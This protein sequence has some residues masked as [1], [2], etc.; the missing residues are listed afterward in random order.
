MAATP[1]PNRLW[2]ATAKAAA[3][4]AVGGFAAWT[5]GLPLAWMIGAMLATCAASVAGMDLAVP[6]PLRA[7]MVVVLGLMLGSR[8]TPEV[9]VYLDRWAISLAA[10]VPHIIVSTAVGIWLLRRWGHLDRP[11]AYFTATPGGLSEMILVGTAMGGDGRVIA[12][13]H[14][15]RVLL[16]VSFLPVAFTALATGT[17][18]RAAPVAVA[19]I[20][21]RDWAW[22]AACVIGWPIAARLKVP[23][24]QLVGPMVLSAV[25]HLLAFSAAAPPDLLVAVA[26][27]VVGASIG[28]RFAGTEPRD[29]ARTA[30]QAGVLTVVL[31]AVTLTTALILAATTGLDT[32]TLVLAFAPGGLAEMSLVA[33]SLDLDAAF[34]AIHHI[35]RIFLIVVLAPLAFR[36]LLRPDPTAPPNGPG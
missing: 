3:I 25:V 22:F 7:A 11:T 5:V 23:A 24:A 19:D 4:A 17:G 36:V 14:A 8:F 27:V 12:L 20:L 18:D 32:R 26:Q 6:K 33:L 13:S 9:L 35:V 1:Y 16:V 2:I 15:T 29:M 34:V 28:V 10:L 31:V 21:L 30:A